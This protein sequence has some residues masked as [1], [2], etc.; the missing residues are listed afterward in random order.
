M[1]DAAVTLA[2]A[3]ATAAATTATN[4]TTTHQAAPT[5][6]HHPV[7]TDEEIASYTFVHTPCLSLYRKYQK[8]LEKQFSHV[9]ECQHLQEDLALCL[10]QDAVAHAVLHADHQHP[11]HYCTK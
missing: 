7:H 1:F 9:A 8:C 4:T 5:K 11:D 6:T 2:T 10:D 3:T